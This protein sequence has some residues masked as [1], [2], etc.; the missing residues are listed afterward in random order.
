M[1]PVNTINGLKRWSCKSKSK[2]LPEAGAVR[3]I[4]VYDF[5]NT[6]FSSPLPN[7]QLWHPTTIGLLQAYEVF[8]H[9]GWWHNPGILAATGEGIEKE[10]PRGWQG[11]WNETVVSLVETS[12]QEKDTLTVLLTGRGETNFADLVN[13]IANSRKLDFDMV[14]LKP[15]VGPNQQQFISTM[16]FKQAFLRDLVLTYRH[17]DNIR[18]YEDRVKHV[19][20]FREFMER[21]NK[22]FLMQAPDPLVQERS[23]TCTA[24]V[25]HVCEL[26]S[27]LDPQAEIMA[28]QSAI[29]QHNKTIKTGGP[30]PT[31]AP[32]K[33]YRIHEQFQYF[34]YMISQTD[35]ARLITLCNAHAHAIDSGEVKYMASSILITP[36][37]PRKDT[38][39]KVGGRGTKI[40][41]QVTGV[42][43]FEDRIWAA[44]VTPISDKPTYTQDDTPMVILAIRKGSRQIDANRIKNWQP[45]SAEKQFIFETVVDDKVMLKIEELDE[46]AMVDENNRRVRNGRH[47]QNKR[48]FQDDGSQSKDNQNQSPGQSWAQVAQGNRNNQQGG[49]NRHFNKSKNN[50]NNKRGSHAQ[51][52]NNNNASINPNA[53]PTQPQNQANQRRQRGGNA[54]RGGRG[55]GPGG[56]KSL[57]DYG[58]GAFDSPNDNQNDNSAAAGGAMVMNY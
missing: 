54:G 13:R 17:A 38:F 56:Y 39:E 1:R 19:K 32:A 7:P 52:N 21:F 48:K 57:D 9:G 20:G 24:E 50:F 4:H 14:V 41:W 34:G 36:Y 44:R 25:V 42:A 58:G 16:D 37:Y 26:K 6:L 28:V 49:G 22:A 43:R 11:W 53:I 2:E 35:S 3:N 27:S 40:T 33:Y 10:E 55:G 23:T 18:I 46:N 31:R 45:P 30:N 51:F 12:L 15:E 5:D 8:A 47:S 29:N